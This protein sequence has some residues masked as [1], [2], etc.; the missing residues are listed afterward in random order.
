MSA[1]IEF[2]A[3]R[4][5]PLL[6]QLEDSWREQ[7]AWCVTYPIEALQD[8]PLA[9]R[10]HALLATIGRVSPPDLGEYEQVQDVGAPMSYGEWTFGFDVGVGAINHLANGRTGQ[11]L[12]DAQHLLGHVQYQTLDEAAYDEFMDEYMYTYPIPEW[13]LFDYGKLNLTAKAAPERAVWQPRLVGLYKRNSTQQLDVAIELAFDQALHDKYGAPLRALVEIAIPLEA[14]TKWTWSLSWFGKQPTR[15]PETLWF[16]FNPIGSG[17]APWHVSKLGQ[18]VDLGHV[19]LNGSWHLHAVDLEGGVRAPATV[20]MDIVPLDS[21]LASFGVLSPF[22]TPL[23]EP[24]W[25]LGVAFKLVGNIWGTNCTETEILF[26][27]GN[28][29]FFFYLQTP[30]GTPMSPRTPMPSSALRRTLPAEERAQD[31]IKKSK[32][33]PKDKE[34]K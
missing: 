33:R 1:C 7:R 11:A 13:A 26:Y 23:H 18:W 28:V 27:F 2:H 15:I 16:A 21:I 17:D 4:D 14:G 20:A 6:V 31:G 9:A 29:M 10:L 12:A 8:H 25:A 3:H 34:R 22:P 19:R 5:D 30:C 32:T 24:D